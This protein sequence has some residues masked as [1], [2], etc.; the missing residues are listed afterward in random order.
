[1][2]KLILALVALVSI[3]ATCS[4]QDIAGE[5]IPRNVPPV[6]LFEELNC[7]LPGLAEVKAA[8]ER[9][10]QVAAKAALLAYY[11]TKPD[12]QTR[13]SFNAD[14]DTHI[15]DELLAGRFV[16]KDAVL[17]YGPKVE[18]IEWYKVPMDIYWPQFDHEIGRGTYIVVLTNAY[19]Q[20]G[21]DKYVAHLVALLLEFIADCPVED[22]R[23]MRR[24]NNMD[25][26]GVKDI[27][28]EALATEGHPAMMWTLMAAMRRVQLFPRIWQ[29]CVQ[30]PEMTPDA[31][32]PR[33]WG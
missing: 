5:T 7:D 10:D 30:S 29:Y 6:R 16:W 2:E 4:A 8:V 21:D 24:I 25:G 31:Y 20:T 15:A 13:A 1:M 22:G 19:R 12:A 17:T 32:S 28:R 3:A 23:A 26:L 9:G 33:A 14:Y 18:D 27:G 11:R